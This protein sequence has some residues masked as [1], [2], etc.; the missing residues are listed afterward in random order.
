[1]L[2]LGLALCAAGCPKDHPVAA[3]RDASADASVAASADASAPTDA[4]ADAEPTDSGAAPEPDPQIGARPSDETL[5]ELSARMRHLAEAIAQNNPELAQDVL[6]PK[7]AFAATH[8]TKDAHRDWTR[9]VSRPFKKA[10]A[11]A[12]KRA[13]GAAHARFGEFR[14]GAPVAE[15]QPRK[16]ELKVPL[17]RVK[18]S[19]LTLV[20]DGKTQ[21]LDVAEMTSW[22]GNWYVTRLR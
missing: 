5:V 19:R 15:A 17:W 13:K 7:D 21:H 6:F 18:R 9:K 12:H 1:V 14:L 10:V 22:R 16:G 11:S 8:D 2:A 20:I 4:G 3:R